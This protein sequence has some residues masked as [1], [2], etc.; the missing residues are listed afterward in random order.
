M[1]IAC[2]AFLLACLFWLANRALSQIDRALDDA[3]NGGRRG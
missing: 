1:A 3:F 2:V